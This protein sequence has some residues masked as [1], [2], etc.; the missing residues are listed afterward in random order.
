MG[1]YG[2]LHNELLLAAVFA[3][4]LAQVLKVP[5]NLYHGKKL[6]WAW[7]WGSGGMPSS[8]S[9][10]VSALATSAGIAYGFDHYAFALS[11]ILALIVMYDACGVR[12][13]AGEHAQRLNK[14]GEMLL[15][16]RLTPEEKLK[17]FI[18]HTP[19]Q[20][21]FGA[22]LGILVAVGLLFL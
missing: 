9:A 7:L 10:A 15:S 8:H 11:A 14:L 1:V 20:V 6:T 5:I 2:I 21:G 19:L 13:A 17:E 16:E 12:R 4:A 22:V 3:W 18:G